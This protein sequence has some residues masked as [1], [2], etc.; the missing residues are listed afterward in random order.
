MTLLSLSHRLTD[1]AVQNELVPKE[2][3]QLPIGS[4]LVLYS[5]PIQIKVWADRESAGQYVH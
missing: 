2:L 4:N 3:T 5:V 1:I